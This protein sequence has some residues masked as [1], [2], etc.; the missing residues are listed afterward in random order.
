MWPRYVVH[1]ASSTTVR[2]PVSK[3]RQT[4]LTNDTQG[5]SMAS[6]LYI[7]TQ[8]DLIDIHLMYASRHQN[9]WFFLCRFWASRTMHISNSWVVNI[10]GVFWAHQNSKSLIIPGYRQHFYIP[11]NRVNCVTKPRVPF[12]KNL[13]QERE[14][15]VLQSRENKNVNWISEC[16]SYHLVSCTDSH[17][18]SYRGLSSLSII[19][20]FAWSVRS[21]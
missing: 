8:S 14:C 16:H 21:C 2:D 7:G 11:L 1:S 12:T 6:H 18:L 4:D 10:I 3:Q 13:C 17:F 9:I 20:W 19:G 5:Y 15:I